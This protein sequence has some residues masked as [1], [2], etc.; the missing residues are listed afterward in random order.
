[1]SK[2]THLRR[3]VLA[4]VAGSAIAFASAMPAEAATR[5]LLT[6]VVVP[7]GAP[8]SIDVPGVDSNLV[9]GTLGYPAGG[10]GEQQRT[11]VPLDL[12]VV[13]PG[14]VVIASAFTGGSSAVTA[15]AVVQDSEQT[16]GGAV[17]A[18]YQD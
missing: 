12:S 18:C 2:S 14:T 5:H 15:Q 6:Y 1:M 7:G 13:D 3:V 16:T 9:C 10:G 17:A 8:T 4:T 11:D